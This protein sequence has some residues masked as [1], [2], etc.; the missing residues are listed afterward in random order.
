MI[1]L[2]HEC[3]V[4]SL[5]TGNY[6]A[7]RTVPIILFCTVSFDHIWQ[8]TLVFT[9]DFENAFACWIIF[10]NF[11]Q[12]TVSVIVN[13]RNNVVRNTVTYKAFKSVAHPKTFVHYW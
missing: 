1:A 12:L 9:I 4:L 10:W 7:I 11:R 2:K 5:L 6:K 13:L 8:I 3:N